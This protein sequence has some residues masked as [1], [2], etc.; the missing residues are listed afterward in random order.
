MGWR[1]SQD[2]SISWVVLSPPPS[3][4]I[5][6]CF[7]EPVI[8]VT[9]NWLSGRGPN[10]LNWHEIVSFP[11]CNLFTLWEYPDGAPE[12][13]RINI[14]SW[15]RHAHGRCLTLRILAIVDVRKHRNDSL[16]QNPMCVRILSNTCGAVCFSSLLFGVE[17]IDI[18][19]V[20]SSS[21]QVQSPY[22]WM[23]KTYESIFQTFL[24]HHIFL[25]LLQCLAL[26]SLFFML[27]EYFKIPYQAAKSDVVP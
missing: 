4:T 1:A 3:I 6:T 2:R 5:I 23:S 24:R 20:H 16:A 9:F 25:C 15:R 26:F 19:L 27:E 11:R 12:Y 10:L 7:A 22:F 17:T 14:E 21:S 13:V 8:P 18:A